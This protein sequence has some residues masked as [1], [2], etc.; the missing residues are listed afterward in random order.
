MLYFVDDRAQYLV[1]VLMNDFNGFININNKQSNTSSV[2]SR[3]HLVGIAL[4]LLHKKNVVLQ[5]VTYLKTYMAQW[6]IYVSL[7]A[8]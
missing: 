6:S 5:L 2:P 8:I 4:R 3:P 7:V 1:N